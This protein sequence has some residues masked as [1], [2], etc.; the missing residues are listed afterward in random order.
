MRLDYMIWRA[1]YFERKNV[2]FLFGTVYYRRPYTDSSIRKTVYFQFESLIHSF[3]TITFCERV[4]NWPGKKESTPT[5]LT[6]DHNLLG[7]TIINF[8]NGV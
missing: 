5:Q 3:G 7:D 2:W 8:E 4:V 6:W 1:V